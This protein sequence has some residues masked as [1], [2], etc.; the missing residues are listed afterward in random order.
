MSLEDVSN[1]ASCEL[2]MFPKEL[3]QHLCINDNECMIVFLA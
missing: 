2:I 1:G 3:S